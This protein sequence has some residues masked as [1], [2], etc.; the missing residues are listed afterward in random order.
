MFKRKVSV[1]IALLLTCKFAFASPIFY[2]SPG[3]AP[4]GDQAWQAAFPSFIEEDFEGQGPWYTGTNE[5]TVGSI[6]VTTNERVV[7]FGVGQDCLGLSGTFLP[8]SSLGTVCSTAISPYY[9]TPNLIL[10]FSQTIYG[11]GTWIAEYPFYPST[12]NI[13][14]SLSVNASTSNLSDSNAGI[15]GVEGWLG[16]SDKDGFDEI[17]ISTQGL[18]YYFLDHMQIATAQ[19]IQLTPPPTGIPEPSTLAI[20]ALSLIGLGARCFKK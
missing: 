16:V 1:A 20:L 8:G 14:F 12:P 18:E 13:T 10:S 19:P 17:L 5:F 2:S 3:N 6:T 15:G 11:F 4:A 7:D 9:L